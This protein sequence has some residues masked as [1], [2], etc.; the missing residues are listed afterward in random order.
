MSESPTP[1]QLLADMAWLK[2]LA[3]ALAGNEDDADD[4]VQQ[5]WIAA[6]QRAPDA[7]RPLRPWLAKVIRDLAGMRRRSERRRELRELGTSEG[8][9]PTPPDA[10]LQQVRLHRLVADLV[11]ELDEPYRS[12]VVARFVDG[13]SAVDIARSLGIPDSTVRA[14]LREA[15]SRLRAQLDAKTGERK[16]WAP[17]VLA[18]AQRGIQVAKPI[19]PVAL[20][21]ALLALLLATALTIVIVMRSSRNALVAGET[22]ETRDGHTALTVTATN[23]LARDAAG[24]LPGWIVQE[25]AASRR[26][27]GRVVADGEQ[28][29]GA[30]VRLSSEPS[31]AGLV[32]TLE[33]RTDGDGR[34]DFGSQP[35]RP[36]VVGAT[37]PGKLA[38]IHHVDARAPAATTDALV[39][40]LD[41]CA[42]ALYGKVVD[43]S[44]A[45]IPHARILREDVI[46]TE[47]D[48]S[49]TYEL[50]ALPSGLSR[51]ELRIVV[52]ATGFGAV[53]TSLAPVDRARHDFVLSPEAAIGGRA[54]TTNGTP[55]ANAEIVVEPDEAVTRPGAEQ[56]ASTRAATDADGRFR[57]AGLGA[58][59]HLVSGR[60]QG[61]TSVPASVPVVAGE[62][63]DVVLT[64]EAT[65]TVRGRVVTAGEP[66]AGVNVIAGEGDAVSQV[67]GSFVLDRVPI[68][69]IE[70]TALPRRVRVPS[71]RR[72]LPGNNTIE[73]DVEALGSVSGVVR[74]HGDV[75]GHSRV[76][77]Y[78]G[79]SHNRATYTDAN[80]A[81]ALDG[82][83]PDNYMIG[84]DS[85][86]LGAFADKQTLSLA[87][88]EHRV[89]DLELARAARIAGTVVDA[90]NAPV[91]HVFVVF[92]STDVHSDDVGRCV[93]DTVGRFECA[94]I[95][96][97]GSYRASVFPGQDATVP[98]HFVAEPAPVV[99]PDG[100]ATVGGVRFMVDASRMS[101]RGTVVDSTGAAVPDVRVSI[102]GNVG[103]L[104]AMPSAI[105]DP[106]G[107]FEIA[108]LAPGSY[109]LLAE[110]S[111]GTK[112]V[113]R[114]IDAGTTGLSIVVD[115]PSCIPS[116]AQPTHRP[117][118]RIAWDDK[119]E[120]VGWDMP[121]KVHLGDSV[122]VAVYY[123]VLRPLGRSWKA[124]VH[125]D[126][127]KQTR[128]SA[129]HDPLSGRCP[130]SSWQAG[131]VL[132][133]RFT[134]RVVDQAGTYLVR[135]GFFRGWNGH[136][137]N[138]PISDGP[139]ALRDDQYGQLTLA[140]L[141]VE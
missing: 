116:T 129:D 86:T 85:R 104:V 130:T 63:R 19:K 18:F 41:P 67:D 74:R 75:V 138:L 80:G 20:L 126:I 99:V 38:A 62:T 134:T 64:M 29:A 128:V 140:E 131:D 133:D 96:G 81:Y 28:V 24:R 11:L 50:C 109:A 137:I 36:Y 27:A 26:I 55:V 25:G 44:G 58:G 69:D 56:N 110:R 139:A 78:S 15:L 59:R 68:G 90:T 48:G 95:A 89:L 135:I 97:G 103:S 72:I 125:I 16:A 108:S 121:D 4:L 113:V 112:T 123:R 2:R 87:L 42:V 33:Q 91:A 93:T 32:P 10:L 52:R 6:W 5:S 39:L 92:E 84:A 37:A 79:G 77:M 114:G 61:V 47:T 23:D 101:I 22:H 30:L 88:G 54:V 118:G 73:L 49:G 35:P 51:D 107:A 31:L 119:V 7:N 53:T 66:V 120:L 8:Q 83:E 40:V 70:F 57:V 111:E 136:W 12:T 94:S 17:A 105:S 132:V 45:A 43:S 14:R 60:G 34:F 3:I 46:G 65:A 106:K 127:P 71:T 102:T 76:V 100:D 117:I 1:D 13:Q 98:Y 141:I 115:P 82:V 122:D 124:F 21:V 9:P